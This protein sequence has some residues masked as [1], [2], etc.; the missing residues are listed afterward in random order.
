MVGHIDWSQWVLEKNAQAKEEELKKSDSV[1][2]ESLEKARR[3]SVRERMEAEEPELKVD[4]NEYDPDPGVGAT[5]PYNMP[6]ALH[7]P[8]DTVELPDK[9]PHTPSTPK[10]PVDKAEG[11]LPAGVHLPPDPPISEMDETPVP[12]KGKHPMDRPKKRKDEVKKASTVDPMAPPPVKGANLRGPQVM[13]KRGHVRQ[14]HYS[15]E[16]E[17]PEE[18][19]TRV[20]PSLKQ[21]FPHLDDAKMNQLLAATH[22]Y[23]QALKPKPE[24]YQPKP[25]GYD[26]QHVWSNP[27]LHYEH[28]T[29]INSHEIQT[30]HNGKPLA[31]KSYDTSDGGVQLFHHHIQPKNAEQQALQGWLKSNPIL[32]NK[33]H[34]PDYADAYISSYADD[35]NMP[36]LTPED[37][38][39]YGKP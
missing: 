18:H 9:P 23:G 20:L 33:P 5:R 1:K 3:S 12:A 31:L 29:P 2:I 11:S 39:E 21:D 24:T 28:G 10:A 6:G 25:E 4:D 13:S 37:L 7:F 30:F 36:G 26:F 19:K 32:R 14:E 16:D 35:L 27:T 8:P 15:L 38:L 17:T 22:T 34:N